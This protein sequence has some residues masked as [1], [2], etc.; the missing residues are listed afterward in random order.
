[1][2]VLVGSA[3]VKLRLLRVRENRV[4]GGD[5]LGSFFRRHDADTFKSP[6]EGLRASD[7]GF[8]ELPVEIER[9]GKAL[10]DLRGSFLEASAPQFHLALAA[11]F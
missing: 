1:M 11:F 2:D 6:R 3:V 5:E 4:E 7:I 10:E 9:P 8:E